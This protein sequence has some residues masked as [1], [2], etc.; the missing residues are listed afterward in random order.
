MPYIHYCIFYHFAPST[1]TNS[2]LT[3][4]WNS[5]WKSWHFFVISKSFKDFSK[6]QM[7]QCVWKFRIKLIMSSS[8][9]HWTKVMSINQVT[10]GKWKVTH[11]FLS[12]VWH[13]TKK[14]LSLKALKLL[15]TKQRSNLNFGYGHQEIT[16]KYAL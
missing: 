4:I 6:I 8:F 12:K 1:P 15:L 2:C 10:F 3:V 11:F 7:T 5:D 16:V 13:S 14:S 9:R